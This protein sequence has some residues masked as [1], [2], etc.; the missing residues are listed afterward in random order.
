M[1]SGSFDGYSL[2]RSSDY[3]LRYTINGAGLTGATVV[4]YFKQKLS[5]ADNDPKTIRKGSAAPLTGVTL[6]PGANQLIAAIALTPTDF[7][8]LPNRDTVELYFDV[9]VKTS[10]G[11]ISDVDEGVLTIRRSAIAQMP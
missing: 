8:Q 1:N 11:Q 3:Q 4:A 9:N 2:S 5:Q 6:T 7:A 10:T